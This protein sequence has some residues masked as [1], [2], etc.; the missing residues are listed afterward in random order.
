MNAPCRD[1]GVD[2]APGHRDQ[3]SELYMVHDE[4]WAAAGM[5]PD[6]GH[7]CI[8]CLELRL[9]RQLRRDDFVDALINAP[10]WSC[11]NLYRLRPRTSRLR[12]RLFGYRGRRMAARGPGLGQL[13][14][15]AEPLPQPQPADLSSV[16]LWD[17]VDSD[18][19]CYTIAER[20]QAWDIFRQRPDFHLVMC[21]C[22]EP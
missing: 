2:V 17:I 9:G 8:G 18:C 3:P 6:G 4:L 14:L 20:E 19:S 16:A 1:C 15:F 12:A 13:G 21:G 10:S 22:D 11:G 5:T 7:L